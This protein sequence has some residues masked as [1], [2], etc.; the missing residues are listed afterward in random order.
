MTSRSP[1]RRD[2]FPAEYSLAGCS[3][4]EPASAGSTV[5]MLHRAASLV[6]QNSANGNLDFGP[7]LTP[8]VHSRVLGKVGNETESRR[9]GRVLTQT[10]KP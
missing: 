10:L 1:H 8:G 4:A 6:E 7:C 5:L 3:P 2:E 9:D